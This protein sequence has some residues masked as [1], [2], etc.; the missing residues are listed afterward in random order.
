MG[1]QLKYI[2]GSGGKFVWHTLICAEE[3]VL[4]FPQHEYRT[5]AEYIVNEI[6]RPI[7]RPHDYI[8]RHNLLT[9]TDLKHFVDCHTH[10]WYD[11]DSNE[12]YSTA[13]QDKPADIWLWHTDIHRIKAWRAVFA[14]ANQDAL[15]FTGSAELPAVQNQLHKRKY[16]VGKLGRYHCVDWIWDRF[17][18]PAYESLCADCGLTPN[19]ESARLLHKEYH[20]CRQRLAKY[21]LHWYRDVHLP[22]LQ[23][24]A[25]DLNTHLLDLDE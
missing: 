19:V 9:E 2:A 4:A 11:R 6:Y 8:A 17:D 3:C 15:D 1:Y 20:L 16:A 24:V 5:S 21:W 12:F 14:S 18:A 25:R 13:V 23:Q 10:E 22:D 7:R